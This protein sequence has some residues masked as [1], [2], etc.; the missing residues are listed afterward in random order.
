MITLH[1]T[2]TNIILTV[3]P[4]TIPVFSCDCLVVVGI[5]TLQFPLLSALHQLAKYCCAMYVCV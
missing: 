3:G 1:H 4:Q 2:A 5:E